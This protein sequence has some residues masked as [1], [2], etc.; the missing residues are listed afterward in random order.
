MPFKVTYGLG[1]LREGSGAIQIHLALLGLSQQISSVCRNSRWVRQPLLTK[2]C[3]T[4][5]MH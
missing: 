3:S 1:H 2:Q 5:A 4:V